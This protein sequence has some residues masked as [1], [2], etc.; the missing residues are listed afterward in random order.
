MT[1]A[2]DLPGAPPGTQVVNLPAVYAQ[3]D[4]PARFLPAPPE[5]LF[6]NTSGQVPVLLPTGH[7]DCVSGVLSYAIIGV[8]R[9]AIGGAGVQ[10]QS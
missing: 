8:R 9:A 3:A 2:G 4:G 5:R 1:C 7:K 6:G 10:A